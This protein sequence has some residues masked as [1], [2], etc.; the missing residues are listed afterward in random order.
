MEKE[1]SYYTELFYFF[2]ISLYVTNPIIPSPPNNKYSENGISDHRLLNWY[3]IFTIVTTTPALNSTGKSSLLNPKAINRIPT[4]PTY[5][6]TT[7]SVVNIT[8]NKIN[9]RPAIIIPLRSAVLSCE[10]R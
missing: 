8:C 9:T 2:F 1:F 10:Q 5:I 3:T 7:T 6:A 4:N